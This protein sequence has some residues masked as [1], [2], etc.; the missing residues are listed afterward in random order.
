M[1]EAEAAADKPAAAPEKLVGALSS[2]LAVLRYLA[3][4]PAPVGVSRIARDLGLHSSTCYNLLKTLVHERLVRFDDATK[5]YA[6]DLG[7][8]E[9]AKGALEQQGYVRMI[10]PHLEAIALAHRVTVTL[11]QRTLDERV[12]LVDRADNDAAVRVYMGIG[13]RLPMYVAA[14]GRAMA[15]CTQLPTAE[16]RTRF[17][18]LRW[19]EPLAFEQYHAEVDEAR[20]LGY[21]TDLGYFSK[22]VTSVAAIVTDRARQPLLAISAVGIGAQFSKTAVKALGQDLKAHAAEISR[23]MSGT[24][25]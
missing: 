10:R 16:L 9:L 13:Q 6:I 14:L 8:V 17:R 1:T 11:W 15:A 5:T 3:A 18:A 2:G 20:R 12:V 4:A 23:A 21:A 7:L 22:G 24:F 25:E 19:E